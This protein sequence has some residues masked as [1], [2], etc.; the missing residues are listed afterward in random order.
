M[1][2]S[3]MKL[4]RADNLEIQ[5]VDFLKIKNMI[6]IIIVSIGFCCL[7]VKAEAAGTIVFDAENAGIT[8][9]MVE[10]KTEDGT[11]RQLSVKSYDYY[12]NGSLRKV[13]SS[14]GK[15][16]CYEG[17]YDP[18]GN[19]MDPSW[20]YFYS[21]YNEG[22]LIAPDS[23]PRYTYDKQGRLT[24]FEAENV[25]VD[26]GTP[27]IITAD[28]EYDGQNRVTHVIIDYYDE[29]YD[30]HF[31]SPTECFFQ[32]GM[33]GSYYLTSE[34][35]DGE[36]IYRES[37]AYDSEH[38][39]TRYES[40]NIF[41][42]STFQKL[43][44]DSKIALYY[45]DEDG[46]LTDYLL[47]YDEFEDPE[48]KTEYRYQK[49]NNR[50]VSCEVYDLEYG[51]KEPKH[52]GTISFSY[53]QNGMLAGK[54]EIYFETR[55]DKNG[56]L[57]STNEFTFETRYSYKSGTGSVFSN[58]PALSDLEAMVA[59]GTVKTKSNKGSTL[60]LPKE[61]QMLSEPFRMQVDNG[62]SKGSIY[63]MPRNQAGHGHLGSVE[64]GTEVWIVA[65]TNDFY[66]FVTDDGQMGWNGKGYFS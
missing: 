4:R 6:A 19:L 50:A 26:T 35:Q 30:Y 36:N 7:S 59:S 45:Y 57:I 37:F 43:S 16:L 2:F 14:D 24:R 51:E 13:R 9:M 21:G 38:H 42:S 65:Q 20:A 11:W 15:F 27:Y 28:Y 47:Y 18:R 33:D 5:G 60:V 39:L 52:T 3:Q 44:T 41:I 54:K 34:S 63:I 10:E 58:A 8:E 66:F 56:I 25:G 53:D 49:N 1:A 48:T 32:Y 31:S 46:L 64:V 17:H 29:E 62:K 12:Q 22:I 55:Y 40:S 61:N 23:E